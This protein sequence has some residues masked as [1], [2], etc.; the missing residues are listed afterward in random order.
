MN[1]HIEVSDEASTH[2]PDVEVIPDSTILIAG[3]GPVGLT[4][5]T[6]LASYGVKSVVLERN[7]TTTRFDALLHNSDKPA[8]V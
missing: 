4:L 1:G 3:G 5:A 6:V 8:W 2:I 7:A